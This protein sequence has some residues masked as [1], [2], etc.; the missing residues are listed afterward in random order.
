MCVVRGAGKETKR[1]TKRI[2]PRRNGE[3][4]SLSMIKCGKHF[5]GVGKSFLCRIYYRQT[6][7]RP[8]T[9]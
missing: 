7:A 2:P 5:E 8:K 6:R 4:S 9:C 3:N 1:K